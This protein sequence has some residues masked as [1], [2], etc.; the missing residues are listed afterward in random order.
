[1][2]LLAKTVSIGANSVE[3]NILTGDPFEFLPY[4]AEVQFGFNQSAIGL[5]IDVHSGQDLLC[6][7]Y[8]P[9]IKVA[10]PNN[11]EMDFSDL[12]GGGE[13]LTVKVT[14]TTGGALDL[15]YRIIIN[16]L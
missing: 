6:D 10:S 15:Y 9:L 12:V 3:S 2:P 14:N 13:R 16:P 11:E 7:S 8:E 5:S 1:M 4:N